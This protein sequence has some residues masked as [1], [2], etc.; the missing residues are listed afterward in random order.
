[1]YRRDA[2]YQ[3]DKK[4]EEHYV[5]LVNKI[6]RDFGPDVWREIRSGNYWKIRDDLPGKAERQKFSIAV[7]TKWLKTKR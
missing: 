6:E 4:I 1:M 7:M 5:R 2:N 3:P